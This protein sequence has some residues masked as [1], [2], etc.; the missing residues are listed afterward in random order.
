MYDMYVRIQTTIRGDQDGKR[1]KKG[2]VNFLNVLKLA[3]KDVSAYWS[4][5]K[6]LITCLIL[7]SHRGDHLLGCDTVYFGRSSPTSGKRSG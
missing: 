2:R 5:I 1:N 3:V 4:I 6:N 7:D